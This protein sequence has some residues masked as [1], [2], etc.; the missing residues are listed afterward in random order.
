M[1]VGISDGGGVAIL[2]M[3]LVGLTVL[4]GLAV[5]MAVGALEFSQDVIKSSNGRKIK[6]IFTFILI[7]YG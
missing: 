7:S 2:L 5:N 3:N 4:N 1:G 6:N